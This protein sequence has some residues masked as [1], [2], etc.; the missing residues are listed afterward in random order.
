MN[1]AR[2]GLLVFAAILGLGFALLQSVTVAVAWWR[3][4]VEP[5]WWEWMWIALLPVWLF[6]FFRYFSILR[7]GAGACAPGD[8]KKL[9]HPGP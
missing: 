5:G 4:Q 6:V 7:P 9:R 1:A 8:P 3:D 2:R